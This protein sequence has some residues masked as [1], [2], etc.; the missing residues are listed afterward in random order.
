M[1]YKKKENCTKACSQRKHHVARREKN[2]K[3][4]KKNY[5]QEINKKSIKLCFS[6]LKKGA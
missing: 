4:K 2:E 5:H 3:R 6:T 1:L